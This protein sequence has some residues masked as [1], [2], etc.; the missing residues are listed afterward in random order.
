M[1]L[2]LRAFGAQELRYKYIMNQDF[3]EKKAIRAEGFTWKKKSL[4]KQW[5]KTKIRANI[6]FRTPP[7]PTTFLMVR[8]LP[9]NSKI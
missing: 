7:P 2:H 8:P 4:H 5:G 6:K 3:T 1:G 9:P